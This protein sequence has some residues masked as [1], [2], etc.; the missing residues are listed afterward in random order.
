MLSRY[1]DRL[2]KL[3]LTTLETRRIRGDLIKVF[4]IMGGHDRI[5]P[6]IF[7]K[8]S[9]NKTTRGHKSKFFKQ[10]CQ[11]NSR[12]FLFSQRIVDF[13]NKLLKNFR[14]VTLDLISR[15]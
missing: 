5:N 3:K 4:K 6:D 9:A 12:K 13:W 15:R 2:K 10:Q 8:T 11:L 7:F 1:P 14:K